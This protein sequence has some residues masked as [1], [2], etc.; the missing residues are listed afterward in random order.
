MKKIIFILIALP[1]IGFGQGWEKTFTVEGNAEGYSVD[2]TLDGGYIVTGRTYDTSYNVSVLLLKTD[3]NGIEQWSQTFSTS[4]DGVGL[5]VK[6]TTDGG[7][8]VTGSMMD[9]INSIDSLFL[10]KTDMN[11]TEQWFYNYLGTGT[12]VD[13]V[14]RSVSQTTDGGYIVIGRIGGNTNYAYLLKTDV[15]GM[16]QWSQTFIGD[17]N[18]GG[19]STE[20]TT[21]GGYIVTGYT[22]SGIPGYHNLYLLKTNMFG[23]EQWSQ[24]FTRTFGWYTGGHSVEQTTDGG[25]I[26]TGTTGS[27]IN[28]HND[29]LYL[30]KTDVN[31]IEQWA[32]TFADNGNTYGN[33]V[34][35][36]V[37]GEY[38]IAGTTSDSLY[39]LKID[40]VGN[41][42]WSQNFVGNFYAEGKSVK[43]TTDGGYVITGVTL[44]ISTGEG[45]VYLVK[46]DGNGNITSTFNISTPNSNRK[47]E[48][49]V[50]ILGRETKP[51]S[52]T[53]FIEIYDDGSA[54][55]K[56]IVE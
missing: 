43:Q 50:D 17:G 28:N 51:K 5:S 19:A 41:K 52:N 20:Q 15:N 10:L 23:V 26:I 9:T 33:S 27:P 49:I 21:D 34:Q 11:G 3:G 55:K 1:M 54:E 8:I 31:G 6:Q 25:Y 53:P 2:Q 38:V 40:G 18:T 13:N 39:L 56:L 37:N 35:Q 16:K 14:G 44:D 36:T 47:L 42:L 4:G 12:A 48:T 32:R 29:S 24:T 45:C 46:T 22:S 7:Y 30:L